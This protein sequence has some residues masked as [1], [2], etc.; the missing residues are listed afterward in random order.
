[1]ADAVGK[2]S[3]VMT[4]GVLRVVLIPLSWIVL[5]DGLK[6]AVVNRA[7]CESLVLN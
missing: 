3:E 1:M 4:A 2:M 5:C 7:T 6:M